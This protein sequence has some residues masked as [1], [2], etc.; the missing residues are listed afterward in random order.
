M[1]VTGEE[2]GQPVKCGVPVAD[3]VAGLYAGYSILAAIFKRANDGEG[4]YIDCSMLGSLLGISALQTSEYYG[5]RIP[6][7]RLGSAH[8]RNAPYQG[9]QAKDKPFVIAAGNDK[10]WK[11]VLEV[12]NMPHLA[13][14]ERFLTQALRASNQKILASILQPVFLQ[15]TAD[16]WLSAFD[17]KGIPCAPINNF[18]EILNDPHVQSMGLIGDITLPNGIRTKYVGFPISFSNFKFVVYKAPPKLGEHNEEVFDEW[19][20]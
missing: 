20:K 19:L 3:F 6:P 10:L 18:E 9:F 5:N 11:G 15:K 12:V 7:R 2:D 8:P 1:S 14:D 17:E 13:D 4:A 16:E